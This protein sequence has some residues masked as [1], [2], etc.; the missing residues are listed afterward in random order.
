MQ[1]AALLSPAIPTA[2][3]A[4]MRV[5]LYAWMAAE[6]GRFTVWLPVFMA[7]GAVGYFSL[8][9]E[10][11]VWAAAVMLVACSVLAVVLRERVVA[12]AV[13]G[14]VA[15]IAFG[16]LSG[17]LAT[18]QAPPLLAVP[19][20]SVIATAVVRAVEPL[21]RG[22]RVSLERVDL[23]D[24]KPA[25][26]L[27]R[28][29]LRNED[30]T[31]IATGD[32]V[33]IRALLE[34]PSPPAYPGGW[35]LQR[36]AF[37]T[38]LGAYGFALGRAQVVVNAEPSGFRR[39][40][41]LLR[42]TVAARVHAV[43]TGAEAGVTEALLTGQTGSIPPADRAAFRDSGLAHLL[44]IAGLHIGIVMALFFGLTRR[45]LALSEWAILHW[46][47]KQIAALTAL[48][49]GGGYMLLTGAHVPIIRSFAMACLFTLAIL[50]GRR[51][52]SLRGWALAMAVLV[53]LSPN[54]VMG[55]SFQMS[56]AAV[57]A[58]ISGYA[59][60]RPWLAGVRGTRSRFR[61]VLRFIVG[62]ALTSA[63]AGTASAPYGAYHFGRIQL[64]YI[65]ANMAAVPLTAAW[66]MPTA[67]LAL[68]LMPL[69]LEAPILKLTGW[70][71]EA[72]LWVGRSVSALPEATLSVPQAPPWGLA[73]L[74]LGILWLG[75]WRTRLRLLGVPI[76]LLGLLSP[77]F[78]RAPD[79][80]VA[81]DGRLAAFRVGETMFVQRQKGGSA[82]TRDAWQQ[83][84]AIAAPVNLPEQGDAAGGLVS[85]TE[86][87]CWLRSRP[88]G[89]AAL[90]LRGAAPADACNAAVLVSLEPI[91][92]RCRGVR[93]VDRFDVWRNGA[94]AVWLLPDGVH[95]LA[96]RW[97]R[98]AR[99]WVPPPPVPHA[100]AAPDAQPPAPVPQTVNTDAAAPPADPAPSPDPPE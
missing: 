70:G 95:V 6:H 69:G 20:K 37:Y 62:L 84:W 94:F 65:L 40:L 12:R 26:R 50:A 7:A 36:D 28:I 44:A 79:I 82:F 75:I 24:G 85:C 31:P 25:S 9:R 97:V 59:A 53:L 91:R 49:A 29:R 96:D 98:G 76:I 100:R 81:A 52:L 18:W 30:D 46:P 17:Q 22:R 64:Y 93:W 43:L 2:P 60:L 77:L 55:V 4:A 57:L 27:V 63:L 1:R 41:E 16:F 72:V 88:G 74:S 23:G 83:M 42:E 39:R 51:A 19:R 35:D 21:E 32:T 61:R 8:T 45:L 58:L 54:V 5:F 13:A 48:A 10:P 14:I 66:V 92:F 90:L 3:T 99:P 73:V 80:L 78:V 47:C 38:G 71:V 67:L 11:N 89:P 15:A 68:A 87:A 56:F 86:A 34:P 33:R